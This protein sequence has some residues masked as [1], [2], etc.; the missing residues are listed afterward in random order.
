MV[1][2]GIINEKRKINQ[3]KRFLNEKEVIVKKSE[4]LY[5]TTK[6]NILIKEH[7]IYYYK[8]SF[9]NPS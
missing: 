4:H 7:F 2:L 8:I 1:L 6:I 9:P 5:Y 3:I